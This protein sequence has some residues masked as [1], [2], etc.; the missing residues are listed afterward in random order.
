MTAPKDY[1]IEKEKKR[2]FRVGNSNKAW[3]MIVVSI[4]NMNAIL[5]V[6]FPQPITPSENLRKPTIITILID[7]Q[8]KNI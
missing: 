7:G 5:P 1:S 2:N 6:T 4:N 3:L 8:P